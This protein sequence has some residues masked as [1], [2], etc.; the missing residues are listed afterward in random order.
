MSFMVVMSDSVSLRIF[1]FP[2]GPFT[3]NNGER[4][5]MNALI[6]GIPL[7]LDPILVEALKQCMPIPC[8]H[9]LRA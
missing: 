2:N 5:T 6:Y 1:I 8:A 9:V 4:F 7:L 3:F